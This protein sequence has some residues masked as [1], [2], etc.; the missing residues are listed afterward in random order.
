MNLRNLVSALG[1]A[2]ALALCVVLF[3]SCQVYA[4]E[5]KWNFDDPITRERLLDELPRIMGK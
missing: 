3:A 1:C 2:A 5:S 4:F